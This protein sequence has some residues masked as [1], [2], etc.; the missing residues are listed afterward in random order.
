[1]CPCSGTGLN[2]HV[3]LPIGLILF[4]DHPLTLVFHY[5]IKTQTLLVKRTLSLACTS[6]L[7]SAVGVAPIQLAY[8]KSLVGAPVALT[9]QVKLHVSLSGKLQ[10]S[11]AKMAVT[12]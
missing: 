8:L 7:Y 6:R 9:S 4:L 2:L 3:Y 5:A 10:A 1:M 12:Q 11:K